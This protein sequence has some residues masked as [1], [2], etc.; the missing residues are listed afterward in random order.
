MDCMQQ[1][2]LRLLQSAISGQA[3]SLPENFDLVQALP[4]IKKHQLGNLIYYGAANCGMDSKSPVM[5]ELFGI[6]YKS[7]IVDERQRSELQKIM[8]AFDANGIHYMPVKGVLM[9]E[10]YP[11]PDMR[12][13]FLARSRI[14]MGSPISRTK[15]SPPLA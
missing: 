5:Q 13:M 4:L 8:A 11:K 1:G 9:K 15:I 7:M 10:L 12:I 3:M 14:F 2:I 6:T